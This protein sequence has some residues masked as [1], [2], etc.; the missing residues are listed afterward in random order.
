MKQKKGYRR[1]LDA[2]VIVSFFF[3]ASCGHIEPIKMKVTHLEPDNSNMGCIGANVKTFLRS[4]DGR[5][6]YLCGH[7][8]NPGDTISGYW[9]EGAWDYDANGFQLKR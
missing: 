3:L 1:L 8:G 6:A 4:D 5:M 2:F 9:R 7:W